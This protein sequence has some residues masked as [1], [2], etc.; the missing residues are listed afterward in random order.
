MDKKTI[1][2]GFVSALITT[3]IGIT[4]YTIYI[5][6]RLDLSSDAIIDKITSLQLIGKRASI[7]MLLNLPLFYYFLNKKQENKAR[8]VIIAIVLIA[9]ISMINKF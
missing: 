5:G 9:I 1:I 4:L 3:F 7:G 6:L 8:G 2:I